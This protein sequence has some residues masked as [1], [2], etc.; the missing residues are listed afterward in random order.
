MLGA[1]GSS[2]TLAVTPKLEEY[3]VPMVVETSS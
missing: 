3:K 1:W 2:L